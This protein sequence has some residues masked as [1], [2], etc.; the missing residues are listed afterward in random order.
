MV[1]PIGV[2]AGLVIVTIAGSV[3]LIHGAQRRQAWAIVA[4]RF[5]L[6]PA[7]SGILS[8]ERLVGRVAGVPVTIGRVHRNKR[9][10]TRFTAGSP[11]FVRG[12]AGL[13]IKRQ[14]GSSLGQFFQG[15]DLATGDATFDRDTFVQGGAGS[16]GPEGFLRAVLDAE[17]RRTFGVV[18]SVTARELEF[19][20]EVLTVDI[21]GGLDAD[22]MGRIL[23][24]M[25]AAVAALRDAAER[26]ADLP[27]ALLRVT[28]T[29]GEPEVR[30][31]AQATL[32]REFGQDART[33]LAAEGWPS[34]A[35]PVLEL[36]RLTACGDAVAEPGL[37]EFAGVS[38]PLE[39]RGAALRT[40]VQRFGYARHQGSVL[41]ALGASSG[42]DRRAALRL[43]VEAGDTE[44]VPRLSAQ[45]MREPDELA[46]SFAEALGQLEDPRAEPDLVH[47]LARPVPAL[48]CAAAVALGRLGTVRAVASLL[49]LTEGL[50]RDAA[51]KD[52]A[53]EAVRA[54]Q[55]RL[56]PVEAGRLS[57][58]DDDASGRVSLAVQGEGE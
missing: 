32:L 57:L 31:R 30:R 1:E 14:A 15:R 16:D 52:A 23:G 3:A 12:A 50:L 46:V 37:V 28:D 55:G 53:R 40:L 49:P 4:D 24:D 38:Q 9:T 27:A 45:M 26:A 44:Q 41:A 35:D 43:V 11:G 47:L 48:Q 56:G 13:T 2:V 39:L 7:P 18:M 8:G 36:A 20:D 58:A 51:V 25:T 21:D 29:D 19:T 34:L 10:F 54:I 17:V 22:T 42:Q 33:R 6:T 5:Q